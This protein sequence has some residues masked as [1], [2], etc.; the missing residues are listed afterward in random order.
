[1]GIELATKATPN[2]S[3]QGLHFPIKSNFGNGTTIIVSWRFVLD[4]VS[5]NVVHQ[6]SLQPNV[7]QV[8]VQAIPSAHYRVDMAGNIVP[9][10]VIPS[11]IGDM[12]IQ[13]LDTPLF[14]PL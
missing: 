7:G 3:N 11:G 10:W 8:V 13:S 6:G 14:Y 2:E 12:T 4:V 9:V 1:M 5:G